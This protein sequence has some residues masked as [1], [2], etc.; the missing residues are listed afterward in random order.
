MCNSPSGCL[1]SALVGQIEAFV[2]HYN[3]QRYHESINNVTPADI[4]FGRDKA[5][6]K[7]RESIKRKTLEARRLYHRQHAA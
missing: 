7:Q 2:H 6:L 5:I 3:P 4:Y 1:T